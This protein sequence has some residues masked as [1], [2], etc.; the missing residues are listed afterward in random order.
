MRTAIL[1]VPEL[2][3]KVSVHL[4]EEDGAR[5]IEID[6]PGFEPNENPFRVWLNDAKLHENL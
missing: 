2:G 5:V 6:T 1:D 4:S 3:L